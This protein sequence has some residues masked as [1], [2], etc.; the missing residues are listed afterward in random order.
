MNDVRLRI[1]EERLGIRSL[2][3][4]ASLLTEWNEFRTT[5]DRDTLSDL[6]QQL[7]RIGSNILEFVTAKRLLAS[8]EHHYVCSFIIH[9]R[10]KGTVFPELARLA[11][12]SSAFKSVHQELVEDF[13]KERKKVR[14]LR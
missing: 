2:E 1:L 4:T 5:L 7:G 6:V 8:S 14:I 13:L 12:H 9:Q 11:G 10:S 3:A